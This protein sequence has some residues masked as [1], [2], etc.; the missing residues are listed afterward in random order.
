MIERRPGLIDWFE[1]MVFTGLLFVVAALL[2][3]E[4]TGFALVQQ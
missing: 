4:V 1:D 2:L 3:Y